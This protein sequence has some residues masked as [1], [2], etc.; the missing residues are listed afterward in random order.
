MG[1]PETPHLVPQGEKQRCSAC[2]Q[3]FEA[4]SLESLSHMFSAHVLI[5]H[6]KKA[7]ENASRT[8]GVVTDSTQD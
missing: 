4:K 3:L 5:A 2:S 8:V 6:K 7:G 1:K